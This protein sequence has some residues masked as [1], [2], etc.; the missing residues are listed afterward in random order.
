MVSIHYAFQVAPI[1]APSSK[2]LQKKILYKLAKIKIKRE[3]SK[4]T[5]AMENNK[6]TQTHRL[7]GNG[8]K[9]LFALGRVRCFKL[10]SASAR[11]IAV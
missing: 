9:N 2:Y 10:T 3:I 4:L 7:P 11:V 6:I 1:H 5:K 8:A